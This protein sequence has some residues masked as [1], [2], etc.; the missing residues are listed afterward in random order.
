MFVARWVWGS[1]I[2]KSF[3]DSVSGDQSDV[4]VGYIDDILLKNEIIDHNLAFL[5][6]PFTPSE[7][8]RLVRAVLDA[9]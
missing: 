2:G 3:D 9:D 5:R 1:P 8:V 6:K 7:L 4:Y